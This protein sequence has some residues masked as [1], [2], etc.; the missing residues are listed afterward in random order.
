M[1]TLGTI[2]NEGFSCV[3]KEDDDKRVFF[4]ADA[5][6]DADGA[7][8][9]NKAKPAYTTDNTG[10]ELLANGGMAVVNGKVVCKYSWA[11]DIVILGKDNEPKV[12]G[13]NVV[14]SRTWYQKPGISANDPNAYLDSETE[15]YIVVPNLIIQNVDGI[16]RGCKARITYN[17][18]NAWCVV[19]DKGPANKI[20]EL[21]IAA[22]R[23]VGIPSSPRTGGLE[24]PEVLYEIWPG[25]AAEG[26]TLQ[27]A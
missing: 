8:G 16:V 27:K 15:N 14:A 5:D 11:R 6:I 7:N 22:A 9:Q 18:K 17:G 12:F 4:K 2:T 3:I 19:G 21:S 10:S 25:I 24:T 13:K 1:R 20:G 26:Y 23:A